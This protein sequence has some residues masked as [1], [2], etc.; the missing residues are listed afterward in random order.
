MKRKMNGEGPNKESDQ[1]GERPWLDTYGRLYSNGALRIV[2]RLWTQEIWEAFLKETMPVGTDDVSNCLEMEYVSISIFDLVARGDE[3]VDFQLTELLRQLNRTYL[4]VQQRQIIKGTFHENQS[5]RS[6]AKS[7]GIDEKQVRV[8]RA[9]SLNKLKHL[10]EGRTLSQN[11]G[12]E[13]SC[14][15][16]KNSHESLTTQERGDDE[17]HY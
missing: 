1:L 13:Q 3:A 6:I 5:N 14:S 9:R 4:T 17:K 11:I 8:Q 10:L 15:E 2:S 16:P 12:K 7:L